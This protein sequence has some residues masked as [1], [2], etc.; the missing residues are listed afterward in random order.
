MEQ[1]QKHIELGGRINRLRVISDTLI[2][3]FPNTNTYK[4]NNKKTYRCIQGKWCVSRCM[5][6]GLG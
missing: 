1:T 5:L 3:T 4:T 6:Q 2:D